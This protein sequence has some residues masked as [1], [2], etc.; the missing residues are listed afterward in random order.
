MNIGEVRLLQFQINEP[1]AEGRLQCSLRYASF[2]NVP[3]YTALSYHWGDPNKTVPI[4]VNEV[5][6]EV[7]INLE[8]GLR[9][10]ANDRVEYIWADALCINQLDTQEKSLQVP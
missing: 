6:V 8:A 2:P 9:R 3:Q 4:L 1:F 5:E 7:T 10:L